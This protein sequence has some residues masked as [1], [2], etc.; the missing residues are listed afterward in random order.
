MSDTHKEFEDAEII[1]AE[2]PDVEMGESDAAQAH[3]EDQLR[4]VRT[5]E[6][7]KRDEPDTA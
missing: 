1:E 2:G 6:E 7:G 3:L 5:V 4:S